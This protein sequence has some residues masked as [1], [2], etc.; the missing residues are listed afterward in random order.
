VTVYYDIARCRHFA[1]CVRGLPSVFDVRQKPW[2]RADQ[3]DAD[4]VAEVVRRCPTG[5]L[6]YVLTEG[7]SEAPERPTLVRR[8]PEG[9]ILVRGDL[10]ISTAAGEQ[11]EVRAALCGCGGTS[12]I[13]PLCD[14]SCGINAPR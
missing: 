12:K 5:A 2:I 7:A 14:G 3:A 8:L 9:P 13:A 4:R 11:H 10:N 6:H 1:E